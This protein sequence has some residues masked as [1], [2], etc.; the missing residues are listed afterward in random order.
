[1]SAIASHLAAFP[2]FP[3]NRETI[4]VSSPEPNAISQAIQS[5]NPGSTIK[6]EPGQYTESLVIQKELKIIAN[7]DVTLLPS[8]G[9]DGITLESPIALISGFHILTGESQSASAIN[10]V[11]GFAIV[12]NCVIETPIVPPILTHESGS[13]SFLACTITS[14]QSIIAF[15]DANVNLTFQNCTLSAPASVG[16]IAGGSSKVQL[17]GSILR[18]S[19][20]SAV[21]IRE[22]AT[23]YLNSSE[24]SGSRGEGLEILSNSMDSIIESTTIR[25]HDPGAGILCSG[26]GAL[27][28]FGSVIDQC[29]RSVVA[30]NGFRIESRE[31]QYT[32]GN[33]PALICAVDG[34]TISLNGDFGGFTCCQFD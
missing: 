26:R 10:F 18:G 27:K 7:G 28:I 1:M 15:T 9:E 22:S 11:S 25:E 8:P 20:D 17:I 19:G 3:D 2:E 34:A 31:C 23:V 32:N 21:L 29:N 14:A 13:I 5:A 30:L 16:V 33:R 24:I 4:T 12:E 6:V